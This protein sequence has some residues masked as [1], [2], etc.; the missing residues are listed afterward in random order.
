MTK[1][2]PLLLMISLQVILQLF[3]NVVRFRPIHC[4]IQLTVAQVV[5]LQ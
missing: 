4:V 3:L 5:V 2:L 1:T